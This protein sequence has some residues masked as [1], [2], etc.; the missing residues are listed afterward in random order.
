MRTYTATAIVAAGMLGLALT[1]CGG[2][3]SGVASEA[4]SA[5]SGVESAASVFAGGVAEGESAAQVRWPQVCNEVDAVMENNPDANPAATAASLNAI[6]A[7][8]PAGDATVITNLANAYTAV[9]ADPSAA[10]QE[11][12]K[13]AAS[14]AGA[15]C[16]SATQ[17]A[18]P[19]AS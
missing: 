14:A 12:L 9:A 13:A 19:S 4:A 15:A 6:A 17:A 8:M 3:T 16:Q 10:N 5:A 18:S 11:A 7:A 1:G 2:S